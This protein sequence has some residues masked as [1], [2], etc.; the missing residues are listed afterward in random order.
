MAGLYCTHKTTTNMR[1]IHGW[2]LLFL[3]LVQDT[4]A[5]GRGGRWCS[6]Y[7]QT[8]RS[9]HTGN[10]IKHTPVTMIAV[11]V[12]GTATATT[13]AATTNILVPTASLSWHN[14]RCRHNNKH[15]RIS[16]CGCTAPL[17]LLR[18]PTVP[19]RLVSLKQTTQKGNHKWLMLNGIIF[20]S[21]MMKAAL[22]ASLP[23]QKLL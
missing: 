17:L 22:Q 18:A 11:S 7:N 5:R 20:K 1:R 8:R 19:L 14:S 4:M 6:C 10:P 2:V 21:T 3:L 13:A 9:D 15:P 12:V 16:H 23:E